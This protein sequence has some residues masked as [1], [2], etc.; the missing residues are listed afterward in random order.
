MITRIKIDGFKSFSDF[1]VELKPFNVIVGANGSGKSNLLDALKLLR[2]LSKES[3]AKAFS[4]QRGTASELFT[5]YPDGTS[6]QE[7][8]FEVDVFYVNHYGNE[9]KNQFRIRYSFAIAKVTIEKLDRLVV[10]QE[11]IFTINSDTD[12][13]INENIPST[14]KTEWLSN[15]YTKIT[16]LSGEKTQEELIINRGGNYTTDQDTGIPTLQLELLPVMFATCIQTLKFLDLDPKKLRQP[17][18]VWEMKT[19]K[20]DGSNLASTLQG[21]IENN[22]KYLGYISSTLSNLLPAYKQV[23]VK[24]DEIGGIYYIMLQSNDGNWLNARVLSEGTLRMLALVVLQ[25]DDKHSGTLCMEEPENGVHPF[26]IK[27]ILE[28]LQE[29]STDFSQEPEAGEPLRQVILNTHSPVLLSKALE[30][31]KNVGL[32]YSEM[33]TSIHPE[34]EHPMKVSCLYPIHKEAIN[35]TMDV[36]KK[37]IYAKQVVDY[38]NSKDLEY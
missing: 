8:K 4:M 20:D 7:M 11:D 24:K 25:F 9:K 17:S 15:L 33:V 16:H 21:I 5:K 19:Y 29:L 36:D 3:I 32:F 23:E 13:W 14:Y 30:L 6:A 31:E 1:E 34:R 12:T 22:P 27:A 2:D 38:L 35:L 28:L 26:R 37:T 10:T 18:E